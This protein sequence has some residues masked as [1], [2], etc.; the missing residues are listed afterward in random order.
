MTNTVSFN[1]F[2]ITYA[3][4]LNIYEILRH[5]Q[6]P[7]A[8]HCSPTIRY[9]LKY[10]EVS[11]YIKKKITNLL[12]TLLLH[13]CQSYKFNFHSLPNVA[14]FLQ[15]KLLKSGHQVYKNVKTKMTSSG[16]LD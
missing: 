11:F 6:I 7:Y 15:P 8:V 1:I 12:F 10:S 2:H 13:P 4:N 5:K 9:S 3:A 14:G 16:G